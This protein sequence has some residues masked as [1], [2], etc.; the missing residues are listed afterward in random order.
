MKL[1]IQ[2]FLSLFY[3]PAS[4]DFLLDLLFDPEDGCDMFIRN[5]GL[6]PNLQPIGLF[7]TILHLDVASLR[8][9]SNRSGVQ[10]GSGSEVK[11]QRRTDVM[12]DVQSGWASHI[13]RGG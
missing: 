12:M 3:D 10:S 6:S 4:V 1:R 9:G 13:H 5:V 11:P 7:N 2:T 8:A